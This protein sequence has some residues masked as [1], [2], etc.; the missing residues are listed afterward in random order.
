MHSPGGARG[1]SNIIAVR[2]LR[3]RGNGIRR[4]E[5]VV[6]VDDF[7]VAEIAGATEAVLRE[8][9]GTHVRG[10]VG[11]VS[12]RV[13]DLA[14]PF[15]HGGVVSQVREQLRRPVAYQRAVSESH[16]PVA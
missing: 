10:R 12:A 16:P 2:V 15:D 3:Q 4:G 11:P 7:Q 1:A 9:A 5:A 6:L 14:A 8:V 13:D